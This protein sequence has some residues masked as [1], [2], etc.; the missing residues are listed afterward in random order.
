MA[1]VA[2][3][4][5]GVVPVFRVPSLRAVTAAVDVEL[6]VDV[7]VNVDVD[8]E[9]VVDVGVAAGFSIP[10]ASVLGLL[11]LAASLPPSLLPHWRHR[12]WRTMSLTS[13]GAALFLMMGGTNQAR[14]KTRM[15]GKKNP[16]PPQHQHPQQPRHHQQ[17]QHQQHQK[18]RPQQRPR[19]LQHRHPQHQQKP[20]CQST[21]RNPR[22]W[23]EEPN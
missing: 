8:V 21:D 18:Q 23:A 13:S 11:Q 17:P 4:L 9:V 1:K 2:R 14:K 16:L 15:T 22:L 12:I 7:G 6:T 3:M 20:S 10:T 5:L 19:H